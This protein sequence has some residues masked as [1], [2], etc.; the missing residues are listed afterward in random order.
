MSP[1]QAARAAALQQLHQRLFDPAAQREALQQLQALWPRLLA[2]LWSDPSPAVSA[3]AAPAVG[4][5][6]ALAAQAAAAAAASRAAAQAGPA[7][8][9][10]SGAGF[11]SGSAGSSVGGLLFDW[12]LPVLQR[13]V[14]PSG[15]ALA[16]H[17]LVAVLAALRDCLTGALRCAPPQPAPAH[18]RSLRCGRLRPWLLRHAGHAAGPRLRR[19]CFT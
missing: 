5:I 18:A 2:T 8:G 13:R 6:G 1:M 12:L 14:T 19:L 10:A 16:P 17:H 9:A 7:A 15:A 3:A 11:A 4:A